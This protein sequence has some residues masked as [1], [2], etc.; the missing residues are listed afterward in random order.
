MANDMLRFHPTVATTC[1]G[2]NDGGY[3]PMSPDKAK[4]YREG[5]TSIV[6]QCK[7]AGVRVI[8]VGSPGCVDSDTFQQRSRTRR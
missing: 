1:F 5:Q 6:E 2:M 8:V 3:S 4:H 7:K